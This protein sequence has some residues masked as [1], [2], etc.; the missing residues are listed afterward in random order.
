MNKS[1]Q[2]IR[3]KI[4]QGSTAVLLGISTFFLTNPRYANAT[5]IGENTSKV[6]SDFTG[7]VMPALIGL[8]FLALMVKRDWIKII[9]TVGIVLIVAYFTDWSAVKALSLSIFGAIFK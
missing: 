8:I 3:A 2:K 1:K 6:I 7:P 9:S 5:A 4:I